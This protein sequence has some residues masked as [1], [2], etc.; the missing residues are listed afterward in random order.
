MGDVT[1]RQARAEDLDAIVAPLTDDPLG[2]TRESGE[3]SAEAY[4]RA[5]AEIEADPNNFVI[6]ADDNGEVVGTFQITFIPNIS[7]EGGR[8]ALVE[9]VRI[10]D[11]HQ[12]TGLG[13]AMMAHA[14]D[15]ARERDC[16]IVQLTSNKQRPGA[17]AF[18][19]KIGF[20]PSHIGFKLHL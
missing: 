9:A 7:F 6:V 10:A 20:E 2:A 16:K 18:Y 17:I 12:G 15:L 5:F 8:R 19:E 1:F 11:S 3:G 14:A 4:A 13:R